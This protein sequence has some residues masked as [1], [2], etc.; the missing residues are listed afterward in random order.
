[1]YLGRIVEQGDAEAVFNAPSHPYTQALLSAVPLPDPRKE[2]ERRRILLSGDLPSPADVP[3]GCR[4][5]TRCPSTSVSPKARPSGAGTRTP[6]PRPR[7]RP[8][9]SLPLRGGAGSRLT[10]RPKGRTAAHL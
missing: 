10:N 4:F 8:H 3:S 1:M 2:R 9:R 6:R 7:Y 5:R